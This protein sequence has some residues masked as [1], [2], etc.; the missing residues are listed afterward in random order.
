MG[1]RR[2]RNHSEGLPRYL[3][4]YKIK[5]T[6]YYYYKRPDL[7]KRVSLGSDKAIA[8]EAAI[9]ANAQYFAGKIPIID[10]RIAR[11][12]KGTDVTL[13]AYIAQYKAEV[14]PKRRTS[15]KPPS[16]KTV[17]NWE[18][19][20][21]F[22]EGELGAI[23][24]RDIT[25]KDVTAALKKKSESAEAH[26]KHRGMLSHVFKHAIADGL[27]DDNIPD[28]TIRMEKGRKG[29]GRLTL[30]AYQA[31]Y[32]LAGRSLQKAMELSLNALQRREDVRTWR[33]DDSKEDGYVYRVVT[34]TEKFGTLSHLRIPLSLPMVHSEEG[35][36]TLGQFIKS[37]RDNIPCPFVIHE[38]PK[39]KGD[40][41]D[42][43][44]H[45]AQRTGDQ[46]SKE[47]AAARDA[48]GLFDEV[49]PVKRPSFH[50]ILSLG[51]YLRE[52]SGWTVEQIQRL[53]GH[54][55][56]QMTLKYLEGHDWTTID[57]PASTSQK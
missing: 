56:K 54:A 18:Y 14:I 11:A 44:E 24:L 28:K 41:A 25:L 9:Q 4:P 2:S 34:K 49:P 5:G 52:Q 39:R 6:V 37:C 35:Y 16:P 46:L 51:E 32:K 31:I 10:T 19:M 53:R 47:F 21:G 45:W 12:S 13:A 20:L 17:K 27:V 3:H 30:E 50:E 26:N 8:V 36:S 55:T 1:R 7:N 48:T 38:K 33:F 57:F 22:F 29:R 42:E 40:M 15:G 43:K 23:P